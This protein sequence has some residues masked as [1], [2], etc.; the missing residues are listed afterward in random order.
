MKTTV[1]N[2]A[3]EILIDVAIGLLVAMFTYAAL[4]KLLDYEEARTAMANQVFPTPVSEILT[5]LIP[6]IELLIVGGLLYRPTR[7]G[8]L[9]AAIALL[10]VFT[11]YIAV[12]MSNLFGRIP[13]SCGG[14]ISELSYT[15]HIVFN[16]IFLF[17]AL[18]SYYTLTKH[19]RHHHHSIVFRNKKG[20]T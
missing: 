11:I 13:C 20:G 19:T 3:K 18:G 7:I 1:Q 9:K 8:G 16:L 6:T 17:I 10:S 12:V 5:W 15:G 14:I 2:K 4:S